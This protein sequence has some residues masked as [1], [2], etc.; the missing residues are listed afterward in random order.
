MWREL[1]KLREAGWLRGEPGGSLRVTNSVRG[2]SWPLALSDSV[3]VI[4]LFEHLG[5]LARFNRQTVW[6]PV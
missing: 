1:T 3:N 5:G 6:D 2:T 4:R